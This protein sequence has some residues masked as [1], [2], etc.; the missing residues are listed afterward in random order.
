MA[1]IK[2][3]STGLIYRNPKP[4]VR[5]VHA[6][7]PSVVAMDNGELLAMVVLG[8][9]FEAANLHT[10]VARS[11]DQG[12]T[13]ELE[14]PIYPGTTDRLTSDS[15]RITALPGGEV[16]AFLVRADRTGHPDEGLAS[17]ETLGFVP[18]ELLLFRSSDYGHTWS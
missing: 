18:T 13:W 1:Q 12:E 8:E 3:E 16:V 4:H 6:Y 14:G 11:R 5:S 2:C 7:F 15:S 9:A 17:A 10:H